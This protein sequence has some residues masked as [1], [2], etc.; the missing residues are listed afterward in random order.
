MKK[1]RAYSLVEVIVVLFIFVL[2]FS[3]VISFV[4]TSDKNWRSGQNRLIEQREARRGMD[5]M[6]RLIRLSNP[7]WGITID[8]NKILFYRPIFDSNGSIVDLHW[9]I[10][11]IDPNNSSQLIQLEQGQ[12]QV[13]LAQNVESV[14]FV[15]DLPIISIS[16]TT[17]KNTAFTLGSKIMFRNSSTAL[18]GDIESEVPPEGEF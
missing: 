5:T 16:I 3:A 1:I 18:P 11:K 2:L 9:V 15:G 12:N 10:F 8:S 17:R 4:I 7:A 14:S 13:V 6:A